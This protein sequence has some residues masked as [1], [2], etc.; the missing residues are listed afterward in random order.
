MTHEPYSKP[1][2]FSTLGFT[3]LKIRTEVA[4]IFLQFAA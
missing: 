4:A 1:H 2:T 3:A